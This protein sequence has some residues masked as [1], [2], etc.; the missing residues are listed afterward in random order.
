MATCRCISPCNVSS[1]SHSPVHR[2]VVVTIA[3]EADFV[4]IEQ[5]P[6]FAAGI[7]LTIGSKRVLVCDPQLARRKL[8]R[9]IQKPVGQVAPYAGCHDTVIRSNVTQSR[10]YRH[11]T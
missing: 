7:I 8:L 9:E 1:I 11:E 4:S 5:Y 10:V 2:T 6:P 3:E